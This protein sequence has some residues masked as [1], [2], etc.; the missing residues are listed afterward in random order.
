MKIKF[1]LRSLFTVVLCI[2]SIS[3][4]AAD[5]TVNRWIK[6]FQP[7]SVSLS[8][9]KKELNWFKQ[10]A[11]PYK[12]MEIKSVA[13]GIPTH[14]WESK[15]LAKA[16]YEIT[17]IK[18]THDIM[19][20]GDVVATVEK[21]IKTKEKLYH[22]YVNDA[23][24]I[25]TH[26][27]A[28]SALNLSDYMKNEGKGVTNPYLD[29]AD[30]LN[31]ELGQD[32]EKNQLML[33]DQQ[34]ANLYWFRYDWFTNPE[35]K[36]EFK[37]E[38]G[39]ELGV[40]LNWT[41]YEDIAKFFNGKII[42]GKRVYGHMDYGKRCPGLGW[43]F[44]DAWLSMA[45]AGDKGLPNGYPVDEWGIRAEGKIPVGAS[46]SRGGAVNGPAG[47]YALEKYLY[48]MKNY[49]PPYAVAMDFTQSGIVA[50]RGRIAQ[51]IFQYT[52]WLSEKDYTAKESPVTD[53]NGKPLWR[54]AP[55]P[56]GKYWEEGMKI[57]YQ[58]AGSWMIPKHNLTQK[59]KAAAWL[60]AQFCVSKSVCLKKF[61][62]GRTPIR[63]S[64]VNSK[65]IQKR[66]GDFG[67]LVSF[68]KSPMKKLW[69]DTGLNVPYYPSMSAVWWKNI[70]PAVSGEV[71]PQQAMDNIAN[72]M[73]NLMLNMNLKKYSPKLNPK[74]SREEWLQKPGSPKAEIIGEEKG[75]TIS[76]EKLISGWKSR[77]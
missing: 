3:V 13:E 19:A 11:I 21:Q 48:W 12:G 56:V 14:R 65:Y 70:A 52:T 55:S 42:D 50:S 29:L 26:L 18:V 16:F 5:D 41:A 8:D 37:K 63:K 62:V 60:W 54:V 68:Y 34:F 32:Y 28:D 40:P 36:K 38:Y 77:K 45:G 53:D 66:E 44:T 33:P 31:P 25:G 72:D 71:S 67:G 69:T 2:F 58:D 23:D 9:Q 64:T 10:A 61:L 17:G 74:T 27:R 6:E 35:I 20:E 51:Q 73:D 57:G 39:Y 59:E 43:R 1:F 46:V 7:A 47:V 24:L 49:A 30:F 4:Q 76:Y 22:I 75:K 15:V